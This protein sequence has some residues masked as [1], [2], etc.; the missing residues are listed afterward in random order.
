MMKICLVLCLV[1][2]ICVADASAA[3][4]SP[5]TIDTDATTAEALS[6]SFDIDTTIGGGSGGDALSLVFDIDTTIGGGSG[7]EALSLVFEIDT[8][9][10]SGGA[11]AQLSP[12]FTIDTRA[13]SEKLDYKY[14][15]WAAANAPEGQRGME[16][17]TDYFGISNLLAFALGWDK[18]DPSTWYR[19]GVESVEML[20]PS[21]GVLLRAH[22]RNDLP[23]LTWVWSQSGDL[24]AFPNTPAILE[25][26]P[27]SLG[28]VM[29]Q[30]DV[31]VP[32]PEPSSRSHSFYRLEVILPQQ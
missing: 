24:Q 9:D 22:R 2:L 7:G 10:V 23:E 11:L 27:T 31:R 1:S 16:D 26:T 32:L 20:E 18:A 30:W 21:S 5:F 12:M 8:Q 3:E 15:L 4:S 19:A 25:E 17:V 29:E 28:G 14:Q 6:V 13:E